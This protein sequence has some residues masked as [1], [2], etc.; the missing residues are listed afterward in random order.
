MDLM[1]TFQLLTECTIYRCKDIFT[2][3]ESSKE[4]GDLNNCLISFKSADFYMTE[5]ID[6]IK[7]N[8]QLHE[9]PRV[10]VLLDKLSY[11]KYDC[12]NKK[13]DITQ[14]NISNLNS[15]FEHLINSA[16]EILI[17]PIY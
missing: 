4:T 13:D 16:S 10:L 8:T 15:N 2:S 11:F 17:K 14:Y 1:Y 9:D 12:S 6:F 7:S 3:F 5:L